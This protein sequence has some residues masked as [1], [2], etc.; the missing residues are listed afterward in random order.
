[1]AVTGPVDEV[2]KYSRIRL[3]ISFLVLAA[4]VAA[5][6]AGPERPCPVENSVESPA[7]YGEYLEWQEVRGIFPRYGKAEVVDFETGLKCSVQRRAGSHHA[8]V[9]P[10]TAGDTE[11]MKQIFG[12][13]WSWN[14]RAVLVLAGGRRIAGSMNGMPHGG[15]SIRGNN[16]PGHFC[17]HF[18]G[19]KLHVTGREDLAHRIMVWK[20]AGLVDQMMAKS[21]PEEVLKVFFTALDQRELNIAARA[22]YFHS[23]AELIDLHRKA[24]GI[25]RIG[26]SRLSPSAGGKVEVSLGVVFSGGANYQKKGTA[27]MVFHSYCGWRVDYPSVESLLGRGRGEDFD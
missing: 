17:I 6:L 18:R 25:E 10:L 27:D 8:D 12:G 9:Q 3:F 24:A 13:K 20:A 11:I 22:A 4:M 16:F 21:S 23:P 7:V 26:L 5:C 14:R 2:T 19:S 1:M 15:G